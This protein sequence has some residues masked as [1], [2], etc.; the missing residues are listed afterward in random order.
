MSGEVRGLEVPRLRDADMSLIGSL[1]TVRALVKAVT[2]K[3]AKNGKD[4]M[5]VDI[6]DGHVSDTFKLWNVTDVIK[7]DLV[8]GKVI[9]V[10]VKIEDYLGKPS[11]IGQGYAETTEKSESYIEMVENL[12]ECIRHINKAI[13][14]LNGDGIYYH[15]VTS[16][17]SPAVIEEYKYAPAAR[18]L[19]HNIVGG[20]ALH[21]S[22][23]LQNG[24]YLAQVYGL[25]IDLVLSGILLHD[26]GKFR[27][28]K[29][30]IQTGTVDYT[31]EGSLIGHI[32]ICLSEIDKAAEI[33]GATGTEEVML[34]KHIVQSHHGR[35]EW[36]SP[37][38]P[39]I[40]EA[41]L[42]HCLDSLDAQ[43]YKIN[44]ETS[45]LNEGEINY[46]RGVVTYKPK[47]IIGEY[48][49]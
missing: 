42:V 18:S 27:E 21:T 14:L 15:L 37:I 6:G 20:W 40:P 23:M 45:N 41:W 35:K 25:D 24:Y 11:L 31:I 19:H 26:Y 46:D 44:K 39:A 34:L 36:G 3:P 22:T 38:E 7:T 17:L 29:L 32:S 30:N 47:R 48:D 33:I 8:A 10:T 5:M 4:Y 2:I 43:M 1:V 13:G 9:D 16:M 12:D 28:M 49:Y